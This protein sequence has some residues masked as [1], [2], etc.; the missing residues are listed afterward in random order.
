[1]DFEVAVDRLPLV[2]HGHSRHGHGH[3]ESDPN[4]NPVGRGLGGL[5]YVLRRGCKRW[6]RVR[7][8]PGDTN[9]EADEDSGEGWAILL[10]VPFVR[11][12]RWRWTCL[13]HV[14]QSTSG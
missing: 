2:D 3:L 1:M 13:L 5:L 14:P 10:P 8:K 7:H 9:H 4:L 6:S 12:L 11:R